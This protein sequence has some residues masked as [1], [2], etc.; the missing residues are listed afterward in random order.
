VLAAAA[1]DVHRNA[2]E[3]RRTPAGGYWL[4]TTASLADYPQQA[5][6]FSLWRTADGGV[7]LRTWM[8]NAD[9]AS[10]AADASRQLAFLDYQG[11]RPPGAGGRP[12]D[13]NAVL[14]RGPA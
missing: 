10:R 12:T 14:F 3:P 8:L 7:A 5:R 11:G 1:G 13:R 2:I 4:I 9:P 6:A